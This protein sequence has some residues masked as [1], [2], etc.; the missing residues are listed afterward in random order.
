MSFGFQ[1]KVDGIKSAISYAYD[2][3]VIMLAAASNDG[4]NSGIAWPARLH[5]VICVN[6]TDGKG[7]TAE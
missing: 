7:Q 2:K 3:N 4:G 5:E 1:E 6:A